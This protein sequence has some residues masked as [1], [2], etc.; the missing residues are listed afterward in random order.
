MIRFNNF[1]LRCRQM[2]TYSLQKIAE[3]EQKVAQISLPQSPLPAQP[4]ILPPADINVVTLWSG[5][6]LVVTTEKKTTAKTT[7]EPQI[8]ISTSS[9]HL[10]DIPASAAKDNIH[11]PFPHRQKKD[12]IDQQFN[13]FLLLLRDVYL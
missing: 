5:K 3:L 4:K 12:Y 2:L 9:D 11:A 6:P 10:V 1:Y 8:Q 7:D 13:K